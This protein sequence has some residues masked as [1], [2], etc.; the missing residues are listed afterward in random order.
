MQRHRN[1]TTKPPG[2]TFTFVCSAVSHHRL[3]RYPIIIFIV[4]PSSS[5]SLSHHHLHRY[6]IIIFIV[7]PWLSSS[8]SH[9]CLHRY[10]IIVFIVI[11]SSSSSLSHHHL[12][13]YPMIVFIVIPSSSSSLS[14]HHLHLYPII[15]FIV[16][17]SSSS[18]LSHDCLHRYPIIIFI[19]IPSSSSSLSHHRLHRYPIIIFIVIPSS[20]SS[21]SHDCLHRYPIIIFIVIPSSSLSHHRLHRYPIIIFIF[22]PSSSSSLSHHHQSLDRVGCWGT[23]T[24]PSPTTILHRALSWVESRRSSTDSRVQSLMLFSHHHS[25]SGPVLHWVQEVVNRQPC[26]VSDVIQPPPF[27]IGPCP[28]LSPG[29]RQRT[30]VSSLWCYSATTILHRALSWVESRRS[31]TDSRVQSLMLFSHHHSPSGPVLSWVQEVVNGQPCPV[32]DVIQPPPFSIGPCPELSPGG[33]QQTAVSSLWCY[34][35]AT[36]LHRALSWVESRRSSTDSRVQSLMLFSHH[37]SP[38]GPVLSWVQ[39]VVNRQPC[40]VSDVIQPPPFSIGPCP[41][42]SPGGRQRT[43]VSS[44]WCYS[45]TTILHRALS[46]VES[47]RSSTDSRVQSLML[48]SPI[49]QRL[50]LLLFPSTLPCNNSLEMLSVWRRIRTAI[51]SMSLFFAGLL[52][53]CQRCH[54]WS[55]TSNHLSWS[56]YRRSSRFDE[57]TSFKLL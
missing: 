13:R 19:V 35:A 56:L 1:K 22:I 33:R 43:A 30:A 54:Q 49:F 53:G 36:I 9:D 27:S 24:D 45:A 39:E 48:S 42:S 5:S 14:H 11:P 38:S 47:R 40:P 8:L 6:P 28:E 32:S 46:W 7:I 51:A 37:H 3:H 18:S 57:G 52:V 20:S 16:I 4:I 17:P 50:T 15:I 2:K 31:S 29:G 41:E 21:L 12:H 34:S 23:Q 44:L 55:A 26:P 10:P 25:P